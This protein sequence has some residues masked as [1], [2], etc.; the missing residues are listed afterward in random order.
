MGVAEEEI[1]EEQIAEA[2]AET[3][4]VPA[5]RDEEPEPEP[6]EEPEPEPD[7]PNPTPEAAEKAFKTVERSF[8]N[9]TQRVSDLVEVTGL[10]LEPC[11]LCPSQHKGFIDM[12]QAGA[13]PQEIKDVTMYYLG[14]PR[15]QDYEPD[16]DTAVCGTCKGKGRL[17]LP[18]SVAGNESKQCGTC[19]GFGYTPPPS[20]GTARV[21][22]SADVHSPAGEQIAPLDLNEVDV[23]GEPKILP[24]GRPNPNFGLW[25]QYKVE[26]PPYGVT[27]NLTAQDTPA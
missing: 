27:V 13:M 12:S 16:P 18:G 23:S 9:Y 17:A 8:T 24:D 19:R 21:T 25:P 26:V 4:I 1:T 5:L 22:S 2:E 3:F 11:P 15:E 20:D 6:D 7:E 14:F 10:P